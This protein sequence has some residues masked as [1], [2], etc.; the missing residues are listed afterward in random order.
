[1]ADARTL[2]PSKYLKAAD[3][4]GKEHTV[5]ISHLETEEMEG[6]NGMET[7]PV[8]YFQG[9][10][11]GLVLNRTNNDALMSLFGFETDE[12]RGGEII[13]FSMRVSGPNGMTDGIRLRGA[14]KRNGKPDPGHQISSG[15]DATPVKQ[16]KSADIDDEIPF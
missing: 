3:L 11:K 4:K 2:F 6:K 15:P 13:L 5:A 9:R 10:E 1:M 7:K 16:Q 12:W 14:A 8:L